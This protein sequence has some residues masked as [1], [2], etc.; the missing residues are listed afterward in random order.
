MGRILKALSSSR[1]ALYFIL[2]RKSYSFL[3]DSGIP[4]SFSLQLGVI[5]GEEV[6]KFLT[7]NLVP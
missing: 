2:T 5:K 6:L 1:Q 7:V 4:E 3:I